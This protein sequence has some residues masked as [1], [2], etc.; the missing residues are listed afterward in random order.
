MFCKYNIFAIATIKKTV[1]CIAM[2]RFLDTHSS[3]ALFKPEMEANLVYLAIRNLFISLMQQ[4]CTWME[5]SKLFLEYKVLI[6]YWYSLC[7]CLI[8]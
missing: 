6:S 1:Y 3:R 4:L 7:T 2:L 5:H 8:M